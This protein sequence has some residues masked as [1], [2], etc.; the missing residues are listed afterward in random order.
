MTNQ[1]DLML[2]GALAYARRGWPVFPCQPGNKAPAT[3]HGYRDATTDP[4]QITTWWTRQPDLG[5]AVATGS[6]GPD[7]L[8]VDQHG[9]AGSGYPACRRLQLAG[10][11]DSAGTVV[12]TPGGGL[13][14]YFTGSS[15]PSARLPRL[16]LDFRAAGGYVLAPPSQIGG[17]CYR[18]LRQQDAAS[19]LSWQVATSLLCPEA[20]RR[21]SS[22]PA[23][24]AKASSLVAWVARLEHGNRNS[25]LFWAACR[26]IESGQPGLLSELA[27]AAAAT[28]LPDREI[29]RTIAS[30][31]RTVNRSRNPAGRV[32]AV[33]GI[34][35]ARVAR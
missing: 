14:L 33:G 23:P 17:K 24:V 19:G 4:A 13:H 3:R 10:L 21:Q 26:L 15:Q 35:M 29:V 20:A 2:S 11:L 25:G 28:G 34:T 16:H 7:V 30:A 32:G 31:C 9:P 5:I 6:P 18:F 27:G 8:D 12:A 22:R 1:P